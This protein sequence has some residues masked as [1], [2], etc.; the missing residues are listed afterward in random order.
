M[1]DNSQLILRIEEEFSRIV[2]SVQRQ[3]LATA[4]LGVAG[5]AVDRLNRSTLTIRN[6]TNTNR[7][8]TRVVRTGNKQRPALLKFLLDALLKIFDSNKKF[9]SS[10]G[11]TKSL[12]DAARKRILI[13]YGYNPDTK[14][15]I[16]GGYLEQ[17]LNFNGIAEQIG[18][19]LNRSLASRHTLRQMQ[20]GLRDL[21]GR[22]R[23]QGFA[24]AH[25]Y[26]FTRD[27]YAEFDRAIKLEYKERLGFSYA[28]YA[29]TEI[30]TTRDFCS[31][32]IN[33]IYTEAEIL[34]WNALEWQGKKPGDVRIN[35]GGYNCR[36]ALNW[37]SENTALALAERRGGINN[38]N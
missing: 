28:I 16:S 26:R 24:Q 7:V 2:L 27:L 36:H 33:N 6:I 18:Q 22:G 5:Y 4:L 19:A 12:E 8:A 14:Q 1:N 30:G 38:Y 37:I 21:M 35:C 17:I 32:R 15:L 9:Y 11:A 23:R 25:F 20:D 29:G 13:L 10:Q 34:T 3:L 31:D